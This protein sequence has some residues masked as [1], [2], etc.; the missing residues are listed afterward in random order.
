MSFN[1]MSKYGGTD[2][3]T[4]PGSDVLRNKVDFRSQD[5]LDAFEADVTAVRMLELYERPVSG[6]FDLQHIQSIHRHLF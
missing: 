2:A 4:Y 5:A 3:Y 6:R 1:S